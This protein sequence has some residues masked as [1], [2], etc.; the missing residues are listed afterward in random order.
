[1]Q[2]WVNCVKHSGSVRDRTLTTLDTPNN[3]FVNH[4]LVSDTSLLLARYF[5]LIILSKAGTLSFKNPVADDRFCNFGV[6]A[7]MRMV[8]YPN[9]IWTAVLLLWP[10]IDE[11]KR[12]DKV[13]ITTD[14]LV[15]N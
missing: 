10:V 14:E 12:S 4:P 8:H 1:M 15:S 2:H 6:T 3:F 11:V 9:D 7:V 13:Q 5:R